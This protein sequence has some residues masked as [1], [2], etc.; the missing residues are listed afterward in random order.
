MT[1]ARMMRRAFGFALIIAAASALS[2]C[3]AKAS[4]CDCQLTSEHDRR[5]ERSCSS[6]PVI[7][8]FICSAPELERRAWRS[9]SDNFFHSAWLLIR[10]VC[11]ANISVYDLCARA[12]RVRKALPAALRTCKTGSG[13]SSRERFARME[14]RV[15][16]QSVC[17]VNPD[18]M[19]DQLFGQAKRR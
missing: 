6:E 12:R 9:S 18:S 7:G 8:A 1:V 2:N 5:A 19:G 3:A 10:T 4:V 14:M 15:A 16:D 13:L 17:S 11:A